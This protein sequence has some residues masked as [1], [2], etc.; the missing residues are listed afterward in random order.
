[1]VCPTTTYITM[2]HKPT[3]K[4]KLAKE[5]P[6]FQRREEFQNLFPTLKK[7]KHPTHSP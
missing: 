2:P 5:Y 4:P 1:M 6:P 7:I 3:H